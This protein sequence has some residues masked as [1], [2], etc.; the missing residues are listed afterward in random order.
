M[1]RFGARGLAAIVASLALAG[2]CTAPVAAS[3]RPEGGRTAGPPPG[4][5]MPAPLAAATPAA[6]APEA[7]SRLWPFKRLFNTDY[8]DVRD[9]AGRY[10]L[11]PSWVTSGR[12][13]QLVDEHGRA[14]LRF[15]DR[16]HDFHLDGV[17]VFMGGTTVSYQGSLY[18]SK[19]DVIKTLV[20]LLDPAGHGA[21][22]PAPPRV[23]VVDAG[24][25]GT[26]DGT[27]NPRLKLLEK[28]AALDTAVRLQ[29]V[30]QGRG[31][32][33]IMTRTEDRYLG[34]E[35]RPDA[36]NRAHADL[37]ISIHFNAAE[38]GVT[39]TETY[40][41]T[42]QFQPSTQVE[43]DKSMI[44][45]LYPANRH[46]YANILLGYEL[47][48]QVRGSLASSDRGLKRRRLAV[49]RPLECPGVLVESA[50]LSNDAEARRVATPEFRQ[51]IAEAI[52]D[53]VDDYAAALAAA[54]AG[55]PGLAEA[56]ARPTPSH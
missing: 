22:L 36:A 19:I 49:L 44:P 24:H 35:Q 17:R 13:M 46:D 7:P 9:L 31:Y 20:P 55:Q 53:G 28:N 12:V 33:V 27:S 25:G 2:G 41:M 38:P 4:A 15:E 50:Y 32:Q 14:R 37:F 45:A 42:P 10:G 26:D 30:L 43:Q 6:P 52:A 3:N 11:K 48:R 23:I 1:A 54:H 47:H 8:V 34:L 56:R 51:R 21:L 16:D 5:G 40:V 18:V 29:K 39:G